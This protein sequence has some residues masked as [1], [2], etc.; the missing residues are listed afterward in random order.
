MQL[1]SHRSSGFN[2]DRSVCGLLSFVRVVCRQKLDYQCP[3]AGQIKSGTS[4]VRVRGK[5]KVGLAVSVCGANQKIFR[6]LNKETK[7]Y[8]YI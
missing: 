2:K 7:L 1:F 5:S 8:R 4:S 6:F 3:C